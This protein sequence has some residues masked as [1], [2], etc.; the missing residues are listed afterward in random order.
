ME[1]FVFPAV[2]A[3][4]SELIIDFSEMTGHSFQKLFIDL[5]RLKSQNHRNDKFM[6][7]NINNPLLKSARSDFAIARL[8]FYKYKFRYIKFELSREKSFI[9]NVA[10]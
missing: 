3:L 9:R 2:I 1:T 6:Q 4:Q 5:P 8:Y 7:I 10:M